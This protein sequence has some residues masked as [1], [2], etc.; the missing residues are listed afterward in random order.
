MRRNDVLVY[1]DE[2]GQ[3]YC[4]DAME[5]PTDAESRKC[6]AYI[7]GFLDGAVTTDALVAENVADEIEAEETF[8]Q[9]AIRTRIQSRLK[10][11]GPSVYA[12]FCVKK[13][14]PIADV[15]GHVEAGLVGQPRTKISR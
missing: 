7:N 14:V 2:L 10:R 1:L 8:A 3:T 15:V 6:F 12:E 9:R 4:E 5:R 11:Y 13:P